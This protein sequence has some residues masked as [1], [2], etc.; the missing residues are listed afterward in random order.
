M[1]SEQVSNVGR[2]YFVV[3]PQWILKRTIH[4]TLKL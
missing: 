1:R 4:S 3:A 2:S